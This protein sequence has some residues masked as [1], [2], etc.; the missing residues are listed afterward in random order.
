MQCV[1]P[2]PGGVV[3]DP[4][5][6]AGQELWVGDQ[7]VG[8]QDFPWQTYPSVSVVEPGCPFAHGTVRVDSGAGPEQTFASEAGGVGAPTADTLDS[9][10]PARTWI[11]A[12]TC[13]PEPPMETSAVETATFEAAAE[14]EAGSGRT[15]IRS[16]R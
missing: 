13:K 16:A 6:A 2:D 15:Q 9:L 10:E 4:V 8:S 3:G 14:G 12:A 5:G 11:T 1:G 7:T